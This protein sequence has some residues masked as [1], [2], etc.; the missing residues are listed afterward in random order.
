MADRSDPR[1]GCSGAAERR[2]HGMKPYNGDLEMLKR[3][4]KL[5]TALIFGIGSCA[6]LAQPYP[7]KPITLVVPFAAGASADGIARI[8]GREMGTA[9]G[10]QVLVDNKPGGG[11]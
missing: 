2:R 6:A 10:Q 1:R 8:V 5:A 4:R 3:V 7:N 11:G 9:L